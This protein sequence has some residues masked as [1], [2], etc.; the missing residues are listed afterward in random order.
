MTSDK[1]VV[2]VVED[3]IEERPPASQAC[4]VVIYG[5]KI[6]RKYDLEQK[7]IVI[8]RS[9]DTDIR[10]DQES[11]SRSHAKVVNRG[12]S[13]TIRDLGSTNG[14]YINGRMRKEHN[15]ND[16]DFIKI[17]RTIFKF[18]SGGNIE[19][20]Y[21]EEIYML[22]TMDGLTQVYNKRYFSESLERELHRAHRYQRALSLIMLDIDHFK[23][24][25]D[26]FGHLAGDAVLN[27]LAAVL[28]ERVRGEDILARY[29]G[30]EF[31]IIMPELEAE[32]ARIFAEQ[33]L[34]L[35]EDSSFLFE[36]TV[37]PVTVSIGIA[38]ITGEEMK[39]QELIGLADENLYQ[40]KE[41]GRNQVWA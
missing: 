34:K 3:G 16:G 10:I 37:I 22:T 36:D 19:Q 20:A 17:G 11:V 13:V 2:T 15:L 38:T 30:E 35:V 21:H 24:V 39:S 33:L 6:G 40:A 23:K 9:S 26:T 8:G 12:D 7:A 1:T 31:A 14:T 41:N 18:L 32:N 29:G 25:N 4:L 5:E 28:K 27:Q